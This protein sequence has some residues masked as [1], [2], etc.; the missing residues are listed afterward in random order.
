VSAHAVIDSGTTT[1]RLRLWHEGAVRWSGSVA[2]GARDT[3]IEGG[4]GAIR[5]AVRELMMRVRE[6]TGVRPSAAI[7]SGMITS[8]LGLHEVPHLRAPA[9]PRELAAA[10]VRID[11]PDVSEVTFTFI[12]GV[13]TLPAPLTLGTL[14]SGDV[15]RGEETEVTGLRSTLG[16]DGPATFL[17]F[18]SHHKAVDVDREGRIT[19]SRTAITGELLAAVSAHTILKSSLA[20]LDDLALDLDAARA[21][22]QAVHAH[23]FGRALFLVRVGDLLA[24]MEPAAATSFLVGALAALDLPLLAPDDGGTGP[25]VLYGHGVFPATLEA[26]LGA[27]GREVR[28]VGGD[29]SDQAAVEGAVAIYRLGLDTGGTA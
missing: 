7:C 3:A 16:L 18:G 25:V 28:R 22:A 8:N 23:G 4:P 19:A 10:M 15:L 14:A 29:A 13:K 27:T 6:E 11:F 2:A 5:A 12:P 21:G 17:H 1:T 24:G 9:G 26:L 20:P